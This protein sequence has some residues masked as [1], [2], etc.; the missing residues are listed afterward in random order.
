MGTEVV[1]FLYELGVPW[2]MKTFDRADPA[3]RDTEP[4]V[5]MTPNGRMPVLEDPNTGLQIWEV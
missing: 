4:M 1:I 5:S 2:E 3:V